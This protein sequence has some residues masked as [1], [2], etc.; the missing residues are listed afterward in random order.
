ML[1]CPGV[2][3]DGQVSGQEKDRRGVVFCGPKDY[4]AT[5]SAPLG[6]FAIVI[7]SAGRAT[8]FRS[9]CRRFDSVITLPL[10]GNYKRKDRPGT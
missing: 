10:N 2:L 5:G 3:K 9:V 4:E 6:W 7:S 1:G 8:D